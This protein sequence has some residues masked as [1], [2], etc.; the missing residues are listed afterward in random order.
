MEVFLAEDS[1]DKAWNDF[2][3]NSSKATFFQHAGWQDVI[4]KTYGHKPYYLA[5]KENGDVKGILPLFLMKS[6]LFGRKLV[7][8]PFVSYAG[9]CAE[10]DS[11]MRALL[12]RSIALTKEVGADYLELRSLESAVG[13]AKDFSTSESYARLVLKLDSNPDMLWNSL[14]RKTR[15]S[16][17]KALKSNLTVES[18]T[19][20]SFAEEFHRVYSQNMLRLGTPSHSVGFFKS[21]VKNLREYAKIFTIKYGKETAA[22]SITFQFKDTVYLSW[23]SSLEEYLRLC[24]NDILYWEMIRQASISKY[25]YF[26]FGRSRWNTGAFEF[27]LGWNAKPEKLYYQYY[28]NKA[29]KIPDYSSENPKRKIFSRLWSK[30]PQSIANRIGPGIRRNVP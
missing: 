18:G 28:L 10:D 25:A 13:D 27:K 30:M 12:K 1:Q 26:D 7:S 21:I 5:A 23:A 15:N 24:P 2:V 22:A 16:T 3:L 14:D 6:R 4:G 17:R 19:D 20:E 9:I 8:I 29:K 11:T